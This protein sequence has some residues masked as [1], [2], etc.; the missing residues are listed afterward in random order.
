MQQVLKIRSTSNFL[1][2]AIETDLKKFGKIMMA[3]T[4]LFKKNVFNGYMQS[5]SCV[6]K[7]LFRKFKIYKL[8]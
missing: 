7:Q 2:A 4:V 6:F 8:L 3:T 1:N 5:K